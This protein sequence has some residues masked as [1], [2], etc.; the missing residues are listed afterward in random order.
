MKQQQREWR[1]TF[2]RDW[3]AYQKSA[4]LKYK[5]WTTAAM[6][7]KKRYQEYRQSRGLPPVPV[8]LMHA[9]HPRL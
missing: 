5:T 8:H 9:I 1:R 7:E 3:K 4:G 6:D 2:E